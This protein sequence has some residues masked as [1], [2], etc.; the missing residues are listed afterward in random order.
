MDRERNLDEKRP[1]SCHSSRRSHSRRRCTSSEDES[2]ERSRSPRQPHKS[3]KGKSPARPSVE[4]HRSWGER[5][6]DFEEEEVDY[7]KA[8]T[9]SDS[10]TEDQ[11]KT[12]VVEVSERTEKY[13][14]ETER[15]SNSERKEVRDRSLLPKVPATR[16]PQL[17]PIMKSEASTTTKAAAGTSDLTLGGPPQGR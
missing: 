14:Q 2:R 3:R 16:T 9:F 8:V 11:S 5:M 17:D 6:S 4:R 1:R 7:S 10:E 12:T 15:V 13:L